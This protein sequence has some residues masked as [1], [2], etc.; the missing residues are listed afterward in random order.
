MGQLLPEAFEQAKL[1]ITLE[2]DDHG[3][4]KFAID[5]PAKYYGWVAQKPA[6]RYEPSPSW[7]GPETAEEGVRY[8]HVDKDGERIWRADQ[9][10]ADIHGAVLRTHEAQLQVKIATSAG[11]EEHRRV[12]QA[13]VDALDQS[14]AESTVAL[15]AVVNELCVQRFQRFA[16]AMVVGA[17]ALR[18]LFLPRVGGKP[19][20]VLRAYIE[21]SV[22]I[23]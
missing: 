8:S 23:D 20:R 9:A 16:A 7:P 14:I 22:F 4:D 3:K 17:A 21:E 13:K 5:D 1:A 6:S 11:Y 19:P 12:W 10:L 2:H 15:R 18:H